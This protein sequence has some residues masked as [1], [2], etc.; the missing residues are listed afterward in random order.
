MAE[1][2]STME[3]V[4]ERLAAMG[5]TSRGALEAEEIDRD[6]MRLAA[7]FLRGEGTSLEQALADRP[8]AEQ[9]VLM[10][11][12]VRTLLRNIILPRNDEQRLLAGKAISG[13]LQ[14][15]RGGGDLA[16]VFQDLGTIVERYAEHR[17]QLKEQL[18][19]AFS[20]QME[21]LE[22][23]LAQSGAKFKL[24]PAR[25]PKFQEEWQRLQEEL[26]SQYGRALDQHKGLLAQRFG[27]R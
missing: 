7:A 4:M 27:L 1:I 3:K 25:H 14:V 6:G 13:L 10:Q 15:S 2:K 22:A 5:E 17:A 16:M 19:T 24:D 12:M 9:T 23:G 21:Q 26:G 11:G 8:P 20:Q 18:K